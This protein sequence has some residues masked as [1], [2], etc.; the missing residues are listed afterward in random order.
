M[1]GKRIN[2]YMPLLFAALLAAGFILGMTLDRYTGGFFPGIN[3][4]TD[5]VNEV[6]KY[7]DDNYVDTVNRS[8]LEEKAIIGMLQQLDPHSAYIPASEF[9]AANDPLLGSFEG[10]GVQFRIESDTI[11]VVNTIPGGPSEKVGIRAGD[12]IVKVND[13]LVAGV[14]I[15]N[16]QVMHKLKGPKGTNVKVAI[17]RRG[18]KGLAEF[19]II[20][21]VIPTYSLDIAYMV[22]ATT[23]YMRLNNFSATTAEEFHNALQN[24]LGQGM[25]KL[26]VDLQGNT[27][28][29]LQAAVDVA[30][31]FLNKGAL[32]VYTEGTHHPREYFYAEN[33]G[34]FTRG[35]LV[36][37]IDEFSASA[38][39]IFAGAIQDNDRGAIIGRRSFGK[40]L[41]QEQ[42][43]F[44]DGSALRLTIA[45]YHTPTGRCIQ[46][47]YKT[48]EGDYYEYYL[49]ALLPQTAE[50]DTVKVADSL[51]Y[52]TPR[53]KVV[54][55]G[56]GI[57]PDFVTPVDQSEK[58]AYYN[59]L[60]N[61]GIIYRYA[62]DYTDRHRAELNRFTSYNTFDK[63]FIITPVMM[64]ELEDLGK[65]SGITR[66]TGDQSMSDRYIRTIMKAYI[67]RNILDNPG[68]FP[69][70]NQIDPAFM[71]AVSY[72]KTKK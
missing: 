54:Y 55:G 59:A 58:L 72:L 48:G 43:N 71:K 66:P 64:R 10:I 21:D 23:G 50:S 17:F 60:I 9:H 41:V 28:G 63:G 1:E 39:E 6:I 5:K 36:V 29:Y 42:I 40:G 11:T 26:I 46:K 38:A 69:Y 65:K 68:F 32:I 56:G 15:T 30:N 13:T 49:R 51:K 47:P 7:I 2:P 62:F 45:R 25:K 67:G 37:L 14:K 52:R 61:K 33:E 20:R 53:G 35:E 4:R 34:L 8:A 24:L 44:K 22:D 27:G 70:L 3:P 19:T 31:E 16:T 18:T 57:Y 12:R